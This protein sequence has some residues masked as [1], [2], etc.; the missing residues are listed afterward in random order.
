[1][2]LIVRDDKKILQQC[3]DLANSFMLNIIAYHAVTTLSLIFENDFGQERQ[4]ET[5]ETVWDIGEVNAP[6]K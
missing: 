2:L 4:E 5:H 1:M 3:S 6:V